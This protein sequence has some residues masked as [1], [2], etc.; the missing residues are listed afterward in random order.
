MSKLLD[1]LDENEEKTINYKSLAV[2]EPNKSYSLIENF[3]DE[4]GTCTFNYT[5]SDVFDV[6]SQDSNFNYRFAS[7]FKL[8]DAT[9]DTNQIFCE[10]KYDNDHV[11]LVEI[12]AY[13]Q[14]LTS[15]F[16]ELLKYKISEGQIEF[17]HKD[18]VRAEG[19]DFEVVDSDGTINDTG[20]GSL[21]QYITVI[22]HSAFVGDEFKPCYSIQ[23][24]EYRLQTVN[25]L[26]TVITSVSS[27][28]FD[29]NNNW[30][31]KE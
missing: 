17:Y 12:H 15:G 4:N 8:E 23:N 28:G 6:R 14:D 20:I 26:G 27:N 11:K 18:D 3:T 1:K 5:D 30:E 19:D 9:D 24:I 13:G 31:I 21:P 2:K 7:V 22:V 16:N 10:F 29:L 25:S